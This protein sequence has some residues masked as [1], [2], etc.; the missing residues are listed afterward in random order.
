MTTLDSLLAAATAWRDADPDPETR[1]AADAVIAAGD[2]AAL[3][4]C[5]GARL[6]FG[7]A[8][9]RG[10]LGP[11]PGR[12]NRALVR[13]VSAGLGAVV[14]ERVPGAAERGVVIGCDARHMS[15]EFAEDTAAVL[16]GMGLP[17]VLFDDIVS[18]PLLAFAVLNL[19]AAAGVM[20]TASHNPRQDNG[21][22]VYWDNGAQIIPPVDKWVAEAIDAV[23]SPAAV[24]TPSLAELRHAGAVRSVFGEVWDTYVERVLEAR[25]H[26]AHDLGDTQVRAVYTAMHGVGWA[27]LQRLVRAA[28]H[29]PL[30][31]VA[32]QVEPDGDFPTVDFPNPEEPGALDRALALAADRGADLVLANDPDA[33]RLAVAIPD[34]AGGWRKL[35]GNEVG[36]LLARDLLA[37]G[38]QGGDRL[39]A[40]SIV[41]TTLLR[42]IAADFGAR[43]E[44]TLT[45]FKWIANAAIRAGIPFVLGFEEALGYSVGETVRDKDGLSAAL[46]FLDLAALCKARGVTLMAHL[47]S[48]YRQYGVVV[49]GQ[50]SRTLPGLDGSAQIAEA[51]AALRAEPPRLLGGVAVVR[52]RD[53]SRDLSVELDT[54]AEGPVGLPLSDVMIFDLSD[55]SRFIAR[56]SGTEPKIK[57]YFEVTEPMRGDEPLATAEARAGARLDALADDALWVM[58]LT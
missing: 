17:V 19:G 5:F 8:G 39:V 6:Q 43:C 14:L 10:A 48:L 3:Q 20:V 52:V 49:T 46:V 7:T 13:M 26:G 29:A 34:D 27:P 9:I 24:I 31:P 36:V 11:G 1:A 40:C 50:R 44:E 37:H 32:E 22:K 33:D 47:T 45:G 57:L 23:G 53:L 2:E 30:L 51:M 12:M 25:V 16:A 38:P 58:G 28:G 21:Y 56:P 41:S 35:T 42:R 18:T 15:R 4:D 55:G 54:G